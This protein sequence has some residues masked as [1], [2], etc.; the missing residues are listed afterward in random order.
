[1][2]FADGS[3]ARLGETEVQN[4][5]LFD[6][7]FNRPSD[8]FDWHF[9]IYAVLVIENNA[10]GLKALQR[11][12]NHFLYMLRPAIESDGAINGKTKLGCDNDLVAERRER[13]S[14]KLFVRIGTVHFGGIE[15]RDALF[16]GCANDLNALVPVCGGP[17]VGADTHAAEPN[18]RDFQIS[19]VAYLHRFSFR[20]VYSLRD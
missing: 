7:T 3:R 8:I 17:V 13:L 10:V 19:E 12:L 20:I 5:P 14:D 9:R 18:G 16:M 6:Q 11:L 2:R 4:F 15:E 1:M